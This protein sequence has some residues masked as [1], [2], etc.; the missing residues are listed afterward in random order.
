MTTINNLPVEIRQKYFQMCE[1]DRRI[2]EV[3][4]GEIP[5]C[6]VVPEYPKVVDVIP[7]PTDVDVSFIILFV[8][9]I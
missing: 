1:I 4:P 5:Q 9:V 6:E 2:N 8:M 7:Y 3:T